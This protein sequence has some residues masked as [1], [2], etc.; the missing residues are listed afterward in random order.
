MTKFRMVAER[1]H[2]LR[3][4]PHHEVQQQTE[5]GLVPGYDP[6]YST[7]LAKPTLLDPTNVST[8]TWSTLTRCSSDINMLTVPKQQPHRRDLP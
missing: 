4:G 8:T 1:V 5:H 3:V 7:L 6:G 2:R